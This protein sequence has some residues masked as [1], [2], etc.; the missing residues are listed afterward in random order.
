MSDAQTDGALIAG[1]FLPTGDEAGS[2]PGDR[3]F[4]PDVEG[5]RAVAIF[6]VVVGHVDYHWLQ[7]GP[8]GVDV[9]FVISG[10]VITGLLLRERQSSGTIAYLPFYARRAR[11]ILPVALLVIVVNLMSTALLTNS[12]TT[13]LMASDS[14][15]T[16]LFLANFHFSTVLPNV[17]STHPTNLAHYWSLAVEEQFYVV[18]PAF[19][20]VLLIFAGRW[21]QRKLFIVGLTG[22]VLAS[23][24][25]SVVSSR[26]GWF[27]G[28]ESTFTRAWELAIGCL[29]ALGTRHFL[30]LPKRSASV[31]S[32][33]GMGG[34]M[35][36]AVT[37]SW[38]QTPYPGYAAAL[39]V[40]GTT[41]VIVGGT[42]APRWGA[43]TFLGLRPIR[44]IGRRSYSWYLW[45]P[46]LFGME[47]EHTHTN[48]QDLS[49]GSCVLLATFALIVAAATYFLIESPIR[50][51]R[52]LRESPRATLVGAAVLIASCVAVTYAF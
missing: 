8:I 27:V 20:V 47:A 2:A 36:G 23:L 13:V 31:I 37:I 46:V 22:V 30:K 38:V 50:H 21:A 48:I 4:R 10:F 35:L 45:Q 3:A 24:S 43:E 34:I 7:G 19:F 41:L 14:R 15:W 32:W 25:Y 39:P 42:V 17:F 5:L 12:K 51:S 16:A 18:Y 1:R 9:F 44:W 40:I 28:Y 29:V 11:R 33:V 49:V 26:P 52:R 6:L